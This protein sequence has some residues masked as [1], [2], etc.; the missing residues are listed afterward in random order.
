MKLALVADHVLLRAGSERVF[1]YFC[2]EF[3]DADTF[4]SA[5]NLETTWDYFSSRR[6]Q[7]TWLN[8]LVRNHRAFQYSFPVMTHVMESLDLTRYEVVLSLSAS[9][10]KY[11]RAPRGGHICYCLVPTRAL[12]NEERYLRNGVK[13][14]FFDSV[15]GHLRKRDY[16]AA[17]RI[18]RFLCISEYSRKLIEKYYERPADVI[19]SPIEIDRFAISNAKEDHYLLVSRLEA[20]KRLEY[21]VAAF[22]TLGRPL[23]VIGTGADE[24]RLKQMAKPNV[25]FLGEVSDAVLASEYSRAAAVIFTPELEYGLI[26]LEACAA[27]TPVICYGRGGVVETMIPWTAETRAGTPTAMFFY[28]Q[29]ARALI[30]AVRQFE[31]CR[32]DFRPDVLRLHAERW[33][34]PHFRKRIRN[35]V[36]RFVEERE[37]CNILQTRSGK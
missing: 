23:R 2:E 17:Q 14:V 19:H 4:T 12:W 37:R 10:A 35:E 31:T 27:G 8:F 25:Q 5:Y 20:W 24:P 13:K 11:V 30:D 22:N 36:E 15:R 18:D 26:P 33:S 1:Q 29:T 21:A 9:V 3:P 16:R 28:E 34:V 32:S 6:P 7:A